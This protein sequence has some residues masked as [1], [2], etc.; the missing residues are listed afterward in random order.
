M[1]LIDKVSTAGNEAIAEAVHFG[2][3]FGKSA[4]RA[5]AV[6]PWNGVAQLVDEGTNLVGLGKPLPQVQIDNASAAAGKESGSDWTARTLGS[7]VGMLLPFLLTDTTVGKALDGK[8]GPIASLADRGGLAAEIAPF[9]RPIA[10]GAAYGLIFT[11]S[12]PNGNFLAERGI[13]AVTGGVT[14][15]A[16]RAATV[17]LLKGLSAT[18]LPIAVTALA[19]GLQSGVGALGLRFGA[20]VFGGTVAGAASAESNS[21]LHG[22]G[23]AT[24]EE[25]G[26]AAATFAVTGGALE[27]AHMGGEYISSRRAPDAVQQKEPPAAE[28]STGKT[29]DVQSRIADGVEGPVAN[30]QLVLQEK[31]KLDSTLQEKINAFYGKKTGAD[32]TRQNFAQLLDQVSQREYDGV[33]MNGAHLAQTFHRSIGCC[34]QRI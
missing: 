2:S 19:G 7:G 30:S 34:M 31:A 29:M 25:L 5:G 16:Q 32:A 12:D 14:F 22:K 17:G 4:W 18:G 3:V 1:S 27:M 26:Q 23:W 10:S 6:E 21:L 8:A 9:V 24:K 28:A 20:N 13:S 15:G 11:P 33:G